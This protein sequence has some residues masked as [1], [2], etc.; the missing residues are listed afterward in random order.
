[1]S[2]DIINAYTKLAEYQWT[3]A[4]THAQLEDYVLRKTLA[5][6]LPSAPAEVADIGGGAGAQSFPLAAA[7]YEVHLCDITPGL[8]AAAGSRNAETGKKIHEIV[9]A[10]AR[11]LP[12][13]EDSFSAAIVLGPMYCIRNREERAAAIAEIRRVARPG[14]PVFF[15]F[16]LRAAALRY[17]L[18]YASGDSRVGGT[19]PVHTLGLFDWRGF[20]ETGLSNDEQL[21][22][23]LRLHYFSTIDDACAQLAENGFEVL[24]TRGTEGPA[25]SLG[26]SNLEGAPAAVVEQWGEIAYEMCALRENIA[27]CTHL[28]VV[29]RST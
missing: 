10:D 19:T 13:A 15:Q 24:D 7:G 9:E 17:L 25:P 2:R 22:D 27:T 23:L 28:L 20:L 29:A 1:V 11:A 3:R 4:S 14:S 18:E 8:L 21:P 26:Q 5:K 6:Y 12:W 16:F